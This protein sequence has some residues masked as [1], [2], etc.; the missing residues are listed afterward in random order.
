MVVGKTGNSEW[1]AAWSVLLLC[2]VAWITLDHSGAEQFLDGVI[3]QRQIGRLF[4]FAFAALGV[5]N[6][7]AL[8]F[9]ILTW[10]NE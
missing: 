7:F 8:A 3:R 1:M 9:R 5:L 10:R 4:G 6:V 2:I